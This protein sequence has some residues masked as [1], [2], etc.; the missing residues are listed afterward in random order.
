MTPRIRFFEEA[1]DE[2][3]HDRK[4]YRDR[5]DSAEEAFLRELDHAIAVVTDAPFRWP[6][7]LAGTRRYVFQT[8]PFSLVYFIE[9]DSVVIVS[10][11]SENNVPD[12]GS[13]GYAESR[14][15]PP[16]CCRNLLS[17]RPISRRSV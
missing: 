15:R 12:T 2:V 8:Y 14:N 16:Y 1:A 9:D 7:Y 3:E 17:R 6:Q 10:V 11:A 5:S 4:W 13:T